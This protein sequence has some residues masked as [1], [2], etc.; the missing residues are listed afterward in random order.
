MSVIRSAEVLGM[1]IIQGLGALKILCLGLQW[2]WTILLELLWWLPSQSSSIFFQMGKSDPHPHH[3]TF[4]GAVALEVGCSWAWGSIFMGGVEVVVVIV[5]LVGGISQ[6]F[7]NSKRF[8]NIFP[9]LGHG[10]PALTAMIV[11]VSHSVC[12][13][14]VNWD[15]FEW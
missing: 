11:D 5:L 6:S 7:L 3:Y 14:V 8:P 2:L 12:Y 13:N 9:A 4:C 15:V 1:L 10:M